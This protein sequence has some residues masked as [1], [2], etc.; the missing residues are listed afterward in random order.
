[1]MAGSNDRQ[2]LMKAAAH[3]FE[4]AD[5]PSR[6]F[7]LPNASHGGMGDNPE[8]TMAA[9]LDWVAAQPARG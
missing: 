2:D 1:M 4:N 8:K 6:Y 5:I 3:T 7:V 9:V